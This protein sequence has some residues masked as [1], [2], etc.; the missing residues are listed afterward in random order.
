LAAWSTIQF[1]WCCSAITLPT[2]GS[3]PDPFLLKLGAANSPALPPRRSDT[4]A[5]GCSD[6]KEPGFERV[7]AKDIDADPYSPTAR[8]P[9]AWVAHEPFPSH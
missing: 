9:K 1:S 2:I 7:Q 8:H 5:R 4:A 6:A 3:S